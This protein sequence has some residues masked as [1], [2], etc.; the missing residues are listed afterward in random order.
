MR[1]VSSVP[2]APR[3]PP[4]TP[5]HTL[6]CAGGQGGCSRP[7][8]QIRR[9]RMSP[10]QGV[11]NRAFF[12]LPRWPL[13]RACLR[14]LSPRAGPLTCQTTTSGSRRSSTASSARR[15]PTAPSQREGTGR[16]WWT[17]ARQ[18]W[19]TT[20]RTSRTCTAAKTPDCGICRGQ[21]SPLP[22]QFWSGVNVGGYFLRRLI[23]FRWPATRRH[24]AVSGQG[25][26]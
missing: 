22:A 26:G 10:S 15:T 13:A 21:V 6:L 24:S 20:R 14:L 19:R 9:M 4:S 17:R 12:D 2:P 18:P 3:A 8:R 1:L 11:S 25:E 7:L 16:L 5:R 23:A